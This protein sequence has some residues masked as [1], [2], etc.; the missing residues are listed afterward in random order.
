VGELLQKAQRYRFAR[1][2]LHPIEAVLAE[3][4]QGLDG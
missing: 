2:F 3:P 1:D 4:S